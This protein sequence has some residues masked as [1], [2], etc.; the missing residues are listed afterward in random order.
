MSNPKNF[1]SSKL[2][3]HAKPNKEDN[4]TEANPSSA[5][6][7]GSI[8]TSI[9]GKKQNKN[10]AGLEELKTETFEENKAPIIRASIESK[11]R[12][13]SIRKISSNFSVRPGRPRSRVGSTHTQASSTK[14][15]HSVVRKKTKILSNPSIQKIKKYEKDKRSILGSQR[16]ITSNITSKIPGSMPT[17]IFGQNIKMNL[18]QKNK[19]SSRLERAG[20]KKYAA[21]RIRSDSQAKIKNNVDFGME[22]DLEF[23]IPLAMQMISQSRKN[24]PSG[25]RRTSISTPNNNPTLNSLAN[26][27]KNGNDNK[28][29]D[30]GLEFITKEFGQKDFH[31]R[32]HSK[33]VDVKKSNSSHEYSAASSIYDNGGQYKKLQDYARNQHFLINICKCLGDYGAPSY[34]LELS[35]DRMAKFL[36][37]D[38]S[39]KSF[40]GFVLIFFKQFKTFPSKTEVV[41]LS[42]SYNLHKLE[43][44]DALFEDIIRGKISIDQGLSEI[45]VIE[46]MAPLYP[47]WIRILCTSAA[48]MCFTIIAY[49]GGWKEGALSFLL[50]LVVQGLGIVNTKLEGFKNLYHFAS[51]FLVGFVA[52][53]LSQ[54]TC[55]GA[56]SL[57]SLYSLF[58]GLGLT[59]G[60]M[61]LMARSIITGTV[62]VFYS[63]AITMTLSF[64]IQ[65]GSSVFNTIRFGGL[66][67][68]SDLNSTCNGLS[69]YYQF[70][71]FPLVIFFT[72]LSMN[73]PK[74]RWLICTAV[75]SSM[76]SIFWVFSNRLNLGYFST[77]ISSFF[78]GTVSNLCG[79]FL[80]IP[81]F[82]PLLPSIIMLVPGS[83]GVRSISKLFAGESSSDLIMRMITACLSIMIG[84]FT[85]SFVVFPRG[86]T[87]TALI[88]F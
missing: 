55:F 60:V 61:E 64:G 63:L 46:S 14:P 44:I 72:L 43:L 17:S 13:S 31:N 6:N 7:F 58:P 3:P 87:K 78:V 83:V 36:D 71:F 81:P 27:M 35:L 56:V 29:D 39:F 28:N 84:L 22:N 8:L 66:N 50:G 2:N 49:N 45:S 21:A 19:D 82:V 10:N 76:Y 25:S 24:S 4:D 88:T 65:T 80:E 12:E 5:Y 26:E 51:S 79:R 33:L 40:P 69:S 54:Y 75:A 57:A 74:K 52:A 47:A 23:A 30:F 16:G 68:G 77:V 38:A 37:I 85:A 18:N 32:L 1:K 48:S 34:R 41:T 59:I 70:I 86:K 67:N 62:Y 11:Q 15:L 73:I 42:R 9:T 53:S 20:G